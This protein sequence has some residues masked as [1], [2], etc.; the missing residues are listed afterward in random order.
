MKK[1]MAVLCFQFMMGAS[2]FACP[3]CNPDGRESIGFIIWVIGGGIAGMFFFL[4]WSIASG[5]YYKV[6]NPKERVVKLN[7]QTGVKI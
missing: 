4:L 5:H 1:W 6:E 7:Q 3:F 2:L